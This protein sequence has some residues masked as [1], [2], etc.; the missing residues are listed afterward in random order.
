MAAVL[1]LSL[2]LPEDVLAERR[3]TVTRLRKKARRYRGRADGDITGNASA[4][5]MVAEALD[6]EATLIEIGNHRQAPTSE[7]IIS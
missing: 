2:D 7:E 1:R 4:F 6:N 5:R 3:D